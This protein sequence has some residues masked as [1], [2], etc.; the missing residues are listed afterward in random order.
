MAESSYTDPKVI[1]K[2]QLLVNVVAHNESGHGDREMMVGKEKVAICKEYYT[3]PC[4]VH[5]EAWKAVN[6]FFSGGFKTPTTIFC[7]PTG[8]EISRREG[9]MASGELIKE[10]DKALAKAK[11]FYGDPI[12]LSVWRKVKQDLA[13]GDAALKEGL[14]KKAIDFYLKVGKVKGKGMEA[15]SKERLKQVEDK[16]Q[17]LLDEALGLSDPEEKKKALRKLIEEFKNTEIAAKAKKELEGI[18]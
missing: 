8:K 12:P 6:K 9:A 10:M 17:A 15:L 3:I 4:A 13:E 18:K 2:S 7:D 16:G 14:Y 11:A 1:A 5:K